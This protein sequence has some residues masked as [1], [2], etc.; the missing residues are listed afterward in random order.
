MRL[1]QRPVAQDR[2]RGAVGDHFSAVEQDHGIKFADM[3][4]VAYDDPKWEL[5]LDQLAVK[6][7]TAM[8]GENFGQPA[9]DRVAKPANQNSDGPAGPQGNYPFGE[10]YSTTVHVG[11]AVAAATFNTDLVAR[12][13]SFIAEDCLFAGK[14]QL[15]SPGANLHRTPFSGRNFEYYSEDSILSYLMGAAQTKAMQAKGVNAAIKHFVANN[16][17]TNRA[18][19]CTFMNEQGYRQN[20]LKGFEGAFTKG[21]ALATMMSFNRVG[22]STVYQNAATLKNV[23]RGEWGFKGVTITDSA[24]GQTDILTVPC[25]VAGTDTFNADAGRSTDLLKY[26]VK[27]KDGYVLQE[28]RRA[29]KNFYYAMANSNLV[30]GL[31]RETVVHDFVPW[32]QNALLGIE[33]CLGVLAGLCAVM[34]L[35]SLAANKNRRAK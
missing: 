28:L 12:R 34:Y 10:K 32:W 3:I 2:V 27:N 5:F 14:T 8:A 33:I 7:M 18:S 15:W 23:L 21:G 16:Q 29:N 1:Q 19:L 25:L 17:E 20:S 9:L 31:T 35:V 11:E 24:K 22:L 4:G 6:D 13:G 26:L 30:N